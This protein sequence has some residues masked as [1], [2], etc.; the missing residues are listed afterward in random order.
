VATT[1]ITSVEI[2]NPLLANNIG[3]IIIA[4]PIIQLVIPQIVLGDESIACD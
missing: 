4:E 2:T 3:Y 1:I